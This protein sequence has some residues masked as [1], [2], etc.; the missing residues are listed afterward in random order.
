MALLYAVPWPPQ[1]IYVKKDRSTR[2]PIMQG[3]SNGAPTAPPR[4]RIAELVGAQPVTV[5]AAE[6]SA[7]PWPQVLSTSY[8][9]SSGSTGFDTKTYE[10]G[11]ILV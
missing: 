6:L 10:H 7:K 11:Q 1:G 4:P 2:P 3:V 9:M 8:M 5:Q